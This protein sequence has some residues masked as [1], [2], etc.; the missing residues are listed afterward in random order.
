MKNDTQWIDE[1]ENK[2][3][4]LKSKGRTVYYAIKAEMTKRTAKQVET[5][6]TSNEEYSTEF[7]KCGTCQNTYEI[8]ITWEN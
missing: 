4:D 2:I 8:I 3:V 6:F 5:H 1:I 7:R